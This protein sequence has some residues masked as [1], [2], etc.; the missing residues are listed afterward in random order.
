MKIKEKVKQ[1]DD[2]IT[3]IALIITIIVLVILAAVTLNSIFRSNIIG[4]ATNGA[5]NYATE[6]KRENEILDHTASIL[7]SAINDIESIK[8]P[9]N[10]GDLSDDEKKAMIG[11]Y[12]DY[13]PTT[14]TFDDHT[15]S[16]YS[17]YSNNS[18]LSTDSSVKWRILSIESNKLTL[19]SNKAVNNGFCLSAANG[20]NNGV[21]LLNNACKI[22][23]SNNNL[24]ATGRSLNIDDIE[25]YMTYD[26]TSDL[27]Y[28]KE[29]MPSNKD[30]PNIF[31][32]ETTGAPNGTYGERYG[33]SDQDNYISGTTT[34]NSSFKGK[35]T[36]YTFEMSTSTMKNQMYVDLFNTSIYWLASRCANYYSDV[37]RFGFSMF[38]INGRTMNANNL[39]RPYNG[40]SRAIYA[41]RPIVEIELSKVNVGITGY[42]EENT[43]YSIEA[44]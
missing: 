38:Y 22:M 33:L 18:Q 5:I 21:L 41:I 36:Y 12:V 20:Y 19:I 30:Y 13:Q 27:N 17:G 32:L 43:P 26:K 29:Y 15:N 6:A 35:K 42:G 40:E 1:K 14:S 23:Y 8:P 24:G 16:D 37:D 25:R 28:Y 11:Q 34:G 3:L 31:E 44:K 9:I 2:G 10:F 4:L 39:Y 7:E